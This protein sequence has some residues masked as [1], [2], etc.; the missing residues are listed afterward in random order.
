MWWQPGEGSASGVHPPACSAAQTA[1][2]ARTWLRVPRGDS[3]RVQRAVLRGTRGPGCG[4]GAWSCWVSDHQA[5][6]TL[7]AGSLI[8]LKSSQQRICEHNLLGIRMSL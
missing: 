8:L 5:T 6:R 2:V 3:V 4:A 1:A 7:I